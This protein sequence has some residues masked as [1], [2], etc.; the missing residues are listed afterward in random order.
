MVTR[1]KRLRAWE[2]YGGEDEMPLGGYAVLLVAW[3]AGFGAAGVRLA[4]RRA[5][6]HVRGADLALLGIAT[7]KITRIVTKDWVTAPLRAP[8]TTYRESAG[9]GEVREKSRGT[10]LR[11]AVGDLLT[12]E[13]CTGPWVAGALVAAWGNAPRVARAFA[14]LF[15]AVAISD[16]LHEGYETL[17][18]RRRADA[19][20]SDFHAAAADASRRVTQRADGGATGEAAAPPG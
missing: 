5:I 7:H 4:R 1:M 10:G 20:I 3:A 18:A 14:S 6:P 8:F 9:S 13:Y 15:A 19:A 12:C 17:R 11:R 2:Q 16:F